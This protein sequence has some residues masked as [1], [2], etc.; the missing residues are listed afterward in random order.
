MNRTSRPNSFVDLF[1]F[2]VSPALGVAIAF[3]SLCGLARSENDELALMGL[4]QAWQTNIGGAPLAHGVRSFVIWPHTTAKK[5]FVTVR[6][7]NRVIQLINGDEIDQEAVD[8]SIIQGE[9]L[10]TPP[11]LGLAGAQAR[12]EKLVATYKKIGK[13]L[14][15]DSFS[16]RLT[17]I[18]TL[19]STGILVAID[20]ETGAILWKSEAGDS[21][22]EMHGPGVSDDYVVVTNGIQMYVYDL[23]KGNLVTSRRLLF[24]PTGA[25]TASGGKAFIPSIEGRLVAYDILD[26]K[27]APIV[28]RTGT[29]NRLGVIKSADRLFMSWPMGNKFFVANVEKKPALWTS[30]AM[31]EQVANLAV[32]SPKGF[33]YAGRLGTIAHCGTTQDASLLWKNRLATPI[34]KSPVVG[35]GIV[36]VVSDEGYLYSLG[37]DD[38]LETWERPVSNVKDIVAI[39]KEHVYVTN[40]SRSLVALRLADG[41]ETSRSSK[42]LPQ[43]LPNSISD[44][45]YFVT[46]F[47]DL[48]CLHEEG[49]DQPTFI[50]EFGIAPAAEPTKPSETSPGEST[51]ATQESGNIFG[52]EKKEGA[53]AVENV[54]GGDPL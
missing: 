31:G 26:H 48:T 44:R 2:A 9:R 3:T 37:L 24:S 21:R 6:S 13:S 5:E 23:A 30:V 42:V 36:A 22:L 47:G 12:A 11:T 50:T 46:Q 51:E 4:E 8:R 53:E 27:V 45:L 20:A 49:A 52:E 38:G 35:H 34:S 14:D 16:Q 7:G 43:V 15:V 33:V 18:V 25:P 40:S 1:S 19:T 28:L 39:G 41:K 54:F 10:E 29:E 17:Y 32:A